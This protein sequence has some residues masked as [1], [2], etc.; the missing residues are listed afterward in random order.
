MAKKDF[1]TAISGV[2][3][4]AMA[5]KTSIMILEAGVINL[6]TVRHLDG[7]YVPDSFSCNSDSC[8]LER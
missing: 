7:D 4:S 8:P 2:F 6:K 5:M 1:S 3:I